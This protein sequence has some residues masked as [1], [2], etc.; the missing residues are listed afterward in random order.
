MSFLS[1]STITQKLDRLE[2][3]HDW[4][5][6]TSVI[7]STQSLSDPKTATRW[8]TIT[9]PYDIEY[10]LMLR[11][12]MHFGQAQGTPFTE[13]PLADHVDWTATSPSSDEILEGSYV[14]SATLSQL[15]HSVLS[16]CRATAPPDDLPAELTIPEFEG[17]IRRWRET[18]TTSP[19]GR[20]L[21]R[22]KALYSRGTHS[23]ADD[24]K[25]Q[26]RFLHQ[27]QEI[28][29]VILQIINFCIRTGHVL[30]RWKQI[31]NT[32]IFKDSGVYQIHRLRVIHIYEADFNLLLAVKW[33]ALLHYAD[34]AHLIHNGQYGGRPG[35]EATSL[36]L[37]EELRIDISYL[38]RRTLITFDNDAASCYDRI[39]PA[40]ASLINRKYGLH[41]QLAIIHAK[42]LREAK[43]KLRT[44]IGI[45]DTAY[46]HTTQFPLYG[47]G[48]GSGN[49]PVL[50]LFISATLFDV[51]D[52][53]AH[54]ATFQDPTG[55]YAVDLKLSG[56]VDDTNAAL[57][58]WQPQREAGLPIL[59][60][61]LTHDAQTWN[62][63]L[64]ISGGKLE[65][66][67]CS[68]HML[69]FDFKP[70]G[71]PRPSLEI[72]PSIVLKD[73]VTQE[74]IKID[75]LGAAQPHKTLGH[76]KSPAGPQR[77][78]LQTIQAKTQKL[79]QLIGTSSLSRYGSQLAYQAKYVAGLRYV[80]PQCHFSAKELR[81]AESKSMPLIIGKCG[82]CRKTSYA[83]LF[84]PPEYAGGGFV[85]WD[86]IQGTG[87]IQHF[88]KHWRTFT[89]ISTALRIDVA[90]SQWQ[91]GTNKPMLVD[92]HTKLPYL[93]SRWLPSLR[94]ALCTSQSQII[95][96]QPFVQPPERVGDQH[97]MDIARRSK[98]Y[99]DQD[100]SILNYCRLYLHVT[101]IS[102]L[103]NA[104]GTTL[105]P[106]VLT[107]HRPPWFDPDTITV[108]QRRPSDYQVRNKW[109]RFCVTL[110]SIP[111]LGPW[112]RRKHRSLRL[113]RETYSLPGPQSTINYHWFQG[114]YWECSLSEATTG[115]F[116]LT[117]PTLWTP[118]SEAHPI[119]CRARIRRTV[120]LELTPEGY[121]APQPPG[122]MVT[123]K[124]APDFQA[125]L[126]TIPKWEQELL[127]H[128]TW[129]MEPFAIGHYLQ[130]QLHLDDNLMIVSD[131]SSFENSTMSF[132]VIIG[133]ASGIILAENMGPAFGQPSSH[134]AEC[135]GCLS[136]ALILYHLLQ[137][138]RLPLPP[139]IQTV[140]VISDN[141]GM[142]KNCEQRR[143]YTEVYANATL[144]P[145][146]DLLEEIHRA[147]ARCKIQEQALIYKWVKGHQDSSRPDKQSRLSQ[148]AKFNIRADE[149]AGEYQIMVNRDIRRT[150]PLMGA[151]K[152]ILQIDNASQHGHYAQALRRAASEPDF[153]HY[154]TGKHHW[155][156]TTHHEV[157]WLS[158][159]MASRTFH[160]TDVQLLKLVHNQLPTRHHL[161]KFQPWINPKCHHCEAPETFDHIQQSS[162]N[163]VSQRYYHDIATSLN[164]YFDKHNTP[165]D[166]RNSFLHGLHRWIDHS[167][168]QEDD[169]WEQDHHWAGTRKLRHSQR[170]IGWR[171]LIR[172]FLS[173]HWRQFLLKTRHQEKW[174]TKLEDDSANSLGFA[175]EDEDTSDFDPEWLLTEQEIDAA[176]TNEEELDDAEFTIEFNS[177]IHQSSS[178]LPRQP[179]ASTDPT[180]FLAG[181]IKILWTEMST[182]WR[183][184]L[185]YNHKTAETKNSPV[186]VQDNQQQVRALHN[187]RDQVLP[188]HKA[189]YFHENV[190]DFLETSTAQQLGQYI[191]LYQPVI[192]DSISRNKKHARRSQPSPSSPT[193]NP[194]LRQSPRTRQQS[195]NDLSIPQQRR[196]P[197]PDRG[198]NNRLL[199]HPALEEA[200]HRKSTRIRQQVEPRVQ[201][202]TTATLSPPSEPE[203]IS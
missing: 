18:T 58:D 154:L 48:Q 31:V 29:S 44:A 96:D 171:F 152:C 131:G 175:L 129:V 137:F 183:S 109:R 134:R 64:F 132:G 200:P 100:M 68:F 116:V 142:I 49:S 4:P 24:E 113:R 156:P 20:H 102:E 181:I 14:P 166:F 5:L 165:R 3:P 161:S 145:D 143:T 74:D 85:H 180:I 182:L 77:K 95:L 189:S 22:Y 9:D 89:D 56:F 106:H 82:F 81:K 193:T 125:Y 93:E 107:C 117:N 103:R 62:D 11:N 162:C 67:K 121:A 10:Y 133:T 72:P 25:A 159:R 168:D 8:T 190:D 40:F 83:L 122:I 127:A 43:Y 86:T 60:D 123:P 65:L 202:Q 135:T 94:T 149:L 203:T 173:I 110:C 108:I 199:I 45:S 7:D 51:H 91:A 23:I 167:D 177:D 151:T 13:S 186:T 73:S 19:S 170:D 150:T 201:N 104:A 92:V 119:D 140:E 188:A 1:S 187:L 66:S 71:T 15:C 37:L 160:T 174:A 78:Q 120:Y 57:N 76:W 16:A 114:A 138:T 84:L 90:W 36:A 128:I 70:D 87:Q 130:T 28:A 12:R 101:T 79:G 139:H 35:R 42:T 112:K 176:P 59:L 33:R 147:Y 41:K 26:K 172:G 197:A 61:R 179:T 155:G 27:Q 164:E 185:D 184:H 2:I 50:W 153:F 148:D 30:S 146:W 46:S 38:T 98:L 63:L 158:F 194:S 75:G 178:D 198:E 192:L 144:V 124:N 53:I 97:I 191:T 39:I 157:D 21:G 6:P 126:T 32:M 17:K 88:I 169:D 111:T 105:L 47:S 54:G 195:P 136:G 80:L 52:G 115:Q 141:Q 196:P 55:K 34:R 69:R 99:T 118:D 163:P